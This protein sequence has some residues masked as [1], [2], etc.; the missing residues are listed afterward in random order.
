MAAQTISERVEELKEVLNKFQSAGNRHVDQEAARIARREAHLKR[1][2]Q[3]MED[4][5]AESSGTGC[6]IDCLYVTDMA[7]KE[8]TKSVAGEKKHRSGEQ[9]L[10]RDAQIR[11]D[12]ARKAIREGNLVEAKDHLLKAINLL[13]NPLFR[14]PV[15]PLP[16]ER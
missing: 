8:E 7:I 14:H 6:P 16:G 11:E 13:Q 9:R 4:A 3:F 5:V 10:L 2:R 15:K 1:G 12:L